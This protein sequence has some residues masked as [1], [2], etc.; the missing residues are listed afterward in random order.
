MIN[1]PKIIEEIKEKIRKLSK[2]D[3][4]EAMK[5]VNEEYERGRQ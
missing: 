2:E 3:L 1:N 4:E 5:K